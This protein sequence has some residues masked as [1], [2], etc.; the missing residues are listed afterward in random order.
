MLDLIDSKQAYACFY[1]DD[2]INEINK[3]QIA[4]KTLLNMIKSFK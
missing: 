4:K 2:R 3:S 1:S